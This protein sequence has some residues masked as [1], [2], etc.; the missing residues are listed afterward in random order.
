MKVFW[1]RKFDPSE[2]GEPLTLT[3]LIRSGQLEEAARAAKVGD[4]A[5]PGQ[6]SYS[7]WVR[8][9]RL[10]SCTYLRT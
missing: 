7:G 4:S 2:V 8:P 10:M 1:S 5:L 3:P 9:R 6:L